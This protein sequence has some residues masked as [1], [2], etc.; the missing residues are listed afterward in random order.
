MRGI[1][2]R[3]FCRLS[4][5]CLMGKVKLAHEV[6]VNIYLLGAVAVG[7]VGSMDNDFIFWILNIW[8]ISSHKFLKQ[9]Y[10]SNYYELSHAISH[11]FLEKLREMV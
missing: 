9:L 5:G 8:F 10:S 6:V 7:L 4:C 2:R 11:N 1:S 3:F